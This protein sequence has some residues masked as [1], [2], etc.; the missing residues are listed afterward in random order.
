MAQN[1]SSLRDAAE[2]IRPAVD[3]M[4]AGLDP[5]AADLPLIA[6]VRRQARLIDGMPDAVAVSMLPN[7]TGQLL[8]ALGELEDRARRRSAVRPAA[9]N[10]VRVMRQEWAAKAR[11]RGA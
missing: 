5:P 10:P 1:R 7:H 2:L 3:A 8:K 6:L 4:L 11:G 9:A